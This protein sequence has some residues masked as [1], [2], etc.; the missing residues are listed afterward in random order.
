MPWPEYAHDFL[1]ADAASAGYPGR[2]V[3]MPTT[4][5]TADTVTISRELFGRL[6]DVLDDAEQVVADLQE[7][8][9]PCPY[10]EMHALK[11]A[12]AYRQ[13]EAARSVEIVERAPVL[14][15]V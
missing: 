14:A 11:V 12:D 13:L 15:S 9:R 3:S 5:P 7:A 8:T 10:L 2:T 4:T 6:L 1:R